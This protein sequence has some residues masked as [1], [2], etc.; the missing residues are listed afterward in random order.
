MS[1]G[2][3]ALRLRAT[4]ADTAKASGPAMKPA[5]AGT[6]ATSAAVKKVA[7]SSRFR[8]RFE[9]RS[10]CLTEF[11][12]QLWAATQMPAEVELVAD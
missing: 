1:S 9:R 3:F 7:E 4:T 8:A 5:K 2:R 12:Q 11:G 6:M 10:M